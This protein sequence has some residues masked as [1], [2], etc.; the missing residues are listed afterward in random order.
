MHHRSCDKG[1]IMSAE[2]QR[3]ALADHDTA[4]GIVVAEKVLHHC[5]RL[6]GRHDGSLWVDLKKTADI[7]RMIRL[8]MLDHKIIRLTAA[9]SG[10]NIIKPFV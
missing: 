6:G 8:H 7:C 3:A 5:E 1:Q 4:I 9:D 2:R 10:L